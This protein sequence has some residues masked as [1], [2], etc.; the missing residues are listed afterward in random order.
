MF[1]EG[2]RFVASDAELVCPRCH[3]NDLIQKVSSIT[4]TD[5]STAGNHG[6]AA[7][8]AETLA[9]PPRPPLKEPRIAV[10]CVFVSA[11]AAVFVGWGIVAHNSD[12]SNSAFVIAVLLWIVWL[13]ISSVRQLMTQR[14]VTHN[15]Q[16]WPRIE[17]RWADLYYCHRD[18]LV[19][20][21]SDTT[22]SAP[23]SQMRALLF[24]DIQLL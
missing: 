5:G 22:C 8:L 11:V 6:A 23:A 13:I 10:G 15:R 12:I 24:Q 21:G 3:Q 19:F 14:K 9:R 7:G 17:R 16:A 20:Y 18:S 4:A 2:D 1:C